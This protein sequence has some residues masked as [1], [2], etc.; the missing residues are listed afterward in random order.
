M[1]KSDHVCPKRHK[2]TM[3]A[4]INRMQGKPDAATLDASART[5]RVRQ[6]GDGKL[7]GQQYSLYISGESFY[8]ALFDVVRLAIGGLS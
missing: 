7:L 4:Q 5:V 6:R 3:F 8:I 1:G 2:Y